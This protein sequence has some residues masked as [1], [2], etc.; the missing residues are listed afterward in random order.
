MKKILIAVAA[1]GLLVSSAPAAFAG[2]HGGG[3][4]GGFGG[5][6]GGGHGGGWGH[7]GGGYGGGWAHRGHRRWGGGYG[8]GYAY[9]PVYDG[10][11]ELVRTRY[12]WR[13]VCG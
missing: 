2:G 7:H 10:D 12:G 4:G 6:F 13:K 3:H 5:G 9:A 8:W 1:V 11:C